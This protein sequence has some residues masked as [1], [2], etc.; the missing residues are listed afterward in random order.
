MMTQI[1]DFLDVEPSIIK[2][3]PHDRELAAAL[4][5]EGEANPDSGK[6]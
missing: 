6:S 4:H 3:E 5:L 2:A 1:K